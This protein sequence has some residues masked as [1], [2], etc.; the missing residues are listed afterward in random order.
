[1]CKCYVTDRDNKYEVIAMYEY[2]K[3]EPRR[4]E[5]TAAISAAVSGI[6][7][8]V[9]AH[10][11]AAV[12]KYNAKFGG[13]SA[14]KFRVSAREL[15]AA[16]SKV[17]PELLKAIKTAARSIKKFAKLQLG[18]VKP[19]HPVE[20]EK[21]VLLGHSVIPVDSCCCYVPGGNHPLFSTA[22]MLAIP[23]K[24]AGVK[25]VCAAV[26][27]MKNSKL[28]HP[29]TLAALKVAGVDEVY[30]V[31]GAQAIAAVAY[32]TESIKPVAM[33][34]GPGNK[35][36][37]EAKRQA[38]GKVGIDFI[39]GPSEVLIIADS[40]AD[41][42]V[43]AADILAQSEHDIDASGILI[44]TSALLA[45]KVE[46]EVERQLDTLD[47][48][49]IASVSWQHNGRII[50]AK[51]LAEAADIANAIAPEHLEINIK[52]AK[53]F[54]PKLRNY[55]SLFIG[56]WSAEVFGD[57]DAGT[58]HTLPTMGA[59]RYTGG[60]SVMT[61]LKVCT[62]QHVTAEGVKKLG[63]TAVVMAE[64]E[65]LTAHVNAAKIRIKNK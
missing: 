29:A 24:T 18:C 57:Y 27:P 28:P 64:N 59:A 53:S 41:P 62:F 52:N 36:V 21:G 65:G 33:I 10:G 2:K 45:K 15:D 43:I 13:L 19:L 60:V 63:P 49:G 5:E 56:Q 35:Y 3:A 22:L 4:A 1:M 40:S 7:A 12:A 32:G 48:K 26:P 16:A 34:V 58:N 44:T 61:F 42:S 39:A 47:T 50:I 9:R 54:M 11:D 14:K 37:T 31:G 25:R 6:I 55:G 17:S 38:F 8:D 23:A 51:S 20:I 30:A 46:A